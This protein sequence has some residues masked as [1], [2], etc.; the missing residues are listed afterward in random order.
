MLVGVGNPGQLDAADYPVRLSTHPA[1]N[2]HTHTHTHTT[3]TH[4]CGVLAQSGNL[5]GTY[6]AVGFG[7]SG[8]CTLGKDGTDCPTT[9]D[10]YAMPDTDL[11]WSDSAGSVTG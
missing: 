8:M 5:W 1:T 7:G 9:G 2:K 6:T 3:H 4:T 11:P 10:F